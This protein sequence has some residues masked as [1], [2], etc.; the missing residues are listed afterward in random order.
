MI[1]II[2]I[3]LSFF[4]LVFFSPIFII[5]YICTKFYKKDVLFKQKRIGKNKKLFTIFKIRTMK[6]GTNNKPSH[7]IKKEEITKIG[8]L[9][10]KFKL[11]ELPQLWNVF[12]GDMSM[13]GPRPC[14]PIQKHLIEKRLLKNIFDYKPGI[15]GLAQLSGVDMSNPKKLVELDEKMLMELNV[16]IYL[17]Y[18]LFTVIGKKI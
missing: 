17:K 9:L 16:L 18:I 6:L 7:Y 3:I 5:L 2:D 10:R 15:T 11:D 8:N 12:I 1:R 13:V 14:L 4:G